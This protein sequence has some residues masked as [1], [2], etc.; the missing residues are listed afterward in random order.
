MD[1]SSFKNKK[2][3]VTGHTGFKGSWLG[4]WLNILGAKVVGISN[5]VPSMPSHYEYLKDCFYKDLRMDIREKDSIRKILRSFKP[6]YLFHLAAQ[7]LVRHSYIEPILTWETNLMGTINILEQLRYVENKCCAVIITSDKCYDNFEWIW[8]YKETD[9]LGGSDPYSASKAAAEIAISSY[10]KSF[11]IDE[12]N[13]KIVTAR[14]GNVIGGG[15]WAKDRIVP[16]CIRS[17]KDN[18]K[19]KLRNPRSTRPWQHVLEPLGGYLLLAY[20][21]NKSY[22]LHGE[23]FNF[24]PDSLQIRSVEEVVNEMSKYWE[25]VKWEVNVNNN[26]DVYES[27][28]LKLNCDKALHYLNWHSCLSFSKTIKLTVEWYKSFFD[29]PQNISYLSRKQI[30]DYMLLMKTILDF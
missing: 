27:S 4:L 13:V 19:V 3:L 22:N 6:D 14:A 23:S 9:K 28:L 18:L 24:G 29:N 20:S 16:D 25:K 1:F 21:L 12:S 7:P 30:N 5:K 26:K 10:V 11:F 8:G 2:V 17:W 15:D